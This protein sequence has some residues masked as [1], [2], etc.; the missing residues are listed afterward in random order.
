MLFG[1]WAVFYMQAAFGGALLRGGLTL[2]SVR[3]L[4]LVEEEE[5]GDPDEEDSDD[6]EEENTDDD[7]GSEDG[8]DMDGGARGGD[9]QQREEERARLRRPRRPKVFAFDYEPTFETP[10][11]RTCFLLRAATEGRL[12]GLRSVD[13]AALGKSRSIGEEGTARRFIARLGQGGALLPEM[14]ALTVDG[15]ALSPGAFFQLAVALT[16]RATRLPNAAAR[17]AA[18][19]A[20][21][22]ATQ[23][24]AAAPTEAAT[25]VKTMVDCWANDRSIR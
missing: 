13:L 9:Q 4:V 24:M 10:H 20:Q 15:E 14:D 23:G 16:E 2:P 21:R 19:V 3:K 25:A 8:M 18:V 17:A 22:R 7:E 5:Y 12:P 6:D 11:G 1:F